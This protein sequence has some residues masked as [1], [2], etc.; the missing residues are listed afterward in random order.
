M[1]LAANTAST[2]PKPD[3]PTHPPQQA[4]SSGRGG[5]GDHHKKR[6]ASDARGCLPVPGGNAALPPIAPQWAS[7]Y[8]GKAW[9]KR[10]TLNVW[11]PGVLGSRPGVHSPQAMAALTTPP[12]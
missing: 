11:R 1:L 3:A 5:S 9:F 6:K 8:N 10:G 12:P 2:P 4:S 7:L